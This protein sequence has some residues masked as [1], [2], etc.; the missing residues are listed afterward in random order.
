MQID[1]FLIFWGV[2]E[3][4]FE[5][6]LSDILPKIITPSVQ[7]RKKLVGW[8]FYPNNYISNFI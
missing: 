5:N 8:G 7:V 2:S 4:I 6:G 1:I 3:S